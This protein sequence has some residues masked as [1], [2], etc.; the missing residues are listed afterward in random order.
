[1]GGKKGPAGF[2][3]LVGLLGMVLGF[4]GA[5]GFGLAGA[6]IGIAMGVIA[7]VLG[8]MAR[9]FPAKKGLGGLITGV[10]AI[11]CSVAALGLL[12][13]LSDAVK[14]LGEDRAPILTSYAEEVKGGFYHL[15]AKIEADDLD[16]EALQKELA[17]LRG[18]EEN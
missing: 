7:M 12:G 8:M 10:L 1:M 2:A 3:L 17:I 18:E 15:A 13:M 5:I 9:K 6:G 14:D 16:E 4:L 11:G